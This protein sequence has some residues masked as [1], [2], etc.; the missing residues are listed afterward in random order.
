MIKLEINRQYQVKKISQGWLETVV[1]VFQQEVKIS[2]QWDLSL[3]FV[4]E[5]IIRKFNRLYRKKNKS[6]DVLSF[7]EKKDNF[8]LPANSRRS[9]GEIMICIPVARRQAVKSGATLKQEVTRLFI[10]GLAHLAGF[11]HEGVSMAE[12]NKM[13]SLEEKI[14]QKLY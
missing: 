4:D 6:T 10:H 1:R 9:L 2:G 8:I 11:E 14:W 7:E 13:F 3:V 5:A 12:A